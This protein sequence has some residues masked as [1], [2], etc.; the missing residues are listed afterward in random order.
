[1]SQRLEC[2]FCGCNLFLQFGWEGRIFLLSLGARECGLWPSACLCGCDSLRDI[3]SLCVLYH[4]HHTVAQSTNEFILRNRGYSG[5][6]QRLRVGATSIKM[7]WMRYSSVLMCDFMSC[8]VQ[9]ARASV[10]SLTHA[11]HLERAH[12]PLPAASPVP[13]PASPASS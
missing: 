7:Y 10:V 9:L 8:C 2:G 13:P 6:Q 3:D 1:M 4:F 12:N 5:G 11:L